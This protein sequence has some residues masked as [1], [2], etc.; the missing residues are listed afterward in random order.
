M[1][2][3]FIFFDGGKGK[4]VYKSPTL[5]VILRTMPSLNKLLQETHKVSKVTEVE[6]EGKT[7]E[8]SDKNEPT[9][10]S[11]DENEFVASIIENCSSYIV[12][13]V[14]DEIK[15]CDE[16]VEYPFAYE[17]LLA[18]AMQYMHT[19]SMMNAKANV[20]KPVG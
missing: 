11:I 18:I 12:E 20:K 8:K 13:I 3:D 2:T 19:F 7:E 1:K 10:I 4:I 14:H 16:L 5:P 9:T 15:T 17:A 6:E